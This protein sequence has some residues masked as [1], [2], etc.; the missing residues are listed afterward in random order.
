[1]SILISGSLREADRRHVSGGE[2][3]DEVLDIV[4]VVG[5]VARWRS[6]AGRGRPDVGGVGGA[7]V[8]LEGLV[9]RK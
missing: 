9:V 6:V 5:G 1:M 2:R 4:L 3:I 7:G 8:V